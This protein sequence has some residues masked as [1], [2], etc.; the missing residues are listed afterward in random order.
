MDAVV[1]AVAAA[2]LVPARGRLSGPLALVTLT[3]ISL[4]LGLIL[5]HILI[6]VADAAA[7]RLTARGRVVG[8]LAAVQVARRPAVRRIIAIS[9]V[10][11]ALTVFATDA[12]VVG[13]RNREDRARVES[14]AGPSSP[15]R[16]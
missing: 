1:V 3:L 12:L 2:G 4:A 11:T 13:A 16:Q 8:S 6:P 9:T 14:G 15:P 5:A 10:A 7:R